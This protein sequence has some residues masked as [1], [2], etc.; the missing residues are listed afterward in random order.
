MSAWLRWRQCV[1][2]LFGTVL[3]AVAAP[4]IAALGIVVRRDSAGPSVIR[5][6]RVGQ[7]GRVFRMR[8]LRS[9]TA[10]EPGGEAAGARITGTS[11]E[12]VT[13]VG[14]WLR[15]T[16]LDE[17]PQLIDVATGE[18]SLVGPRP[19]VPELVDVDDPRWRLILQARPGIGGPTQVAIADDERRALRASDPVAAYRERILPTKVALDA[20]YVENASPRIDAEV[21][22]S[23]VLRALAP[24][25]TTP[26]EKRLR[27]QGLLP[28][29]DGRVP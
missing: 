6:E 13:R 19:E 23:L 9:M 8:K 28:D 15:A 17:L 10:D 4:V 24:G 2:R 3:A 26:I 21:L 7:G 25:T 16:H 22:I 11:D 18:M 5:L 29:A 1:D 27:A 12:R 20:W 14:R